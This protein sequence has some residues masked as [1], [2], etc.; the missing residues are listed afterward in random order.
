M[1]S[2]QQLAGANRSPSSLVSE[3]LFSVHFSSLI[4]AASHSETLSHLVRVPEPFYYL[5]ILVI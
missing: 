5:I 2:Q 4:P 1:F 3:W